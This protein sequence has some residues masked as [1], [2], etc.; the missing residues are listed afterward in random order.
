MKRDILILSSWLPA[1]TGVSASRMISGPDASH[2]INTED[3]WIFVLAAPRTVDA[4]Q[5]L[6]N[7]EQRLNQQGI[8]ATY[9]LDLSQPTGDST[10]ALTELVLR[11]S[12][13]GVGFDGMT[14]TSSP[15]RVIVLRAGP[16]VKTFLTLISDQA[17]PTSFENL[18]MQ[19][20]LDFHD[21]NR[22]HLTTQLWEHEWWAGAPASFTK[23]VLV[24]E[25]W[26]ATWMPSCHIPASAATN[27]PG[28]HF[29]LEPLSLIVDALPHCEYESWMLPADIDTHGLQAATA[30]AIA[31]L[32][33]ALWP[34]TTP[35]QNEHLEHLKQLA[36]ERDLQIVET[37]LA[38]CREDSLDALLQL[39]QSA[40]LTTRLLSAASS[41]VRSGNGGAQVDL[42]GVTRSSIAVQLRRTHDFYAEQ[43]RTITEL[44]KR[45][46]AQ[47]VAV[48]LLLVADDRDCVDD[49]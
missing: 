33:L 48:L 10:A 24:D 37:A 27:A 39:G 44:G 35:E 47:A 5:E 29:E 43:S 3:D 40:Q 49:V 22:R 1:L 18:W 13:K 31:V 21:W 6:V 26:T 28:A 38:I 4:G 30:T 7:T 19:T 23:H 8:R 45:A 16:E 12:Q 20:H 25:P 14:L 15:N 42:D 17:S 34:T 46:V 2:L 36:H 11:A 32:V 41:A 9:V